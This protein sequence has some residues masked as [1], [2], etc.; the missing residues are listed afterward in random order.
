MRVTFMLKHEQAGRYEEDQARSFSSQAESRFANWSRSN[1]HAIMLWRTLPGQP[2]LFRCSWT[3]F[4]LNGTSSFVRH[5]SKLPDFPFSST[6]CS[7]TQSFR[8]HPPR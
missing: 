6:H 5:H 7:A 2:L 4:G 3:H 8:R 1:D